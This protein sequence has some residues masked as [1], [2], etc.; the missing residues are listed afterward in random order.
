MDGDGTQSWSFV[1]Q[2]RSARRNAGVSSRLREKPPQPRVVHSSG[3]APSSKGGCIFDRR[4]GVRFQTALTARRSLPRRSSTRRRWIDE[5][6]RL[7]CHGLSSC[8]RFRSTDVA[9]VA[10][11]EPAG[12]GE[13]GC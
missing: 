3:G 10:D 12:C 4:K 7:G 1:Q 13:V 9:G 8:G 2:D 11:P 6:V 5:L